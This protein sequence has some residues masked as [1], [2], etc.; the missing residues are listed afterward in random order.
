MAKTRP[1]QTHPFP[2][3]SL[4]PPSL[5]EIVGS[6]LSKHFVRNTREG[7]E[8]KKFSPKK[9][10]ENSPLVHFSRFSFGNRH[11]G[12]RSI[13]LPPLLTTGPGCWTI[14]SPLK[15]NSRSIRPLGRFCSNGSEI[16]ASFK[17]PPSLPLPRGSYRPS[18]FDFRPAR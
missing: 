18:S 16:N 9:A 3:L 14:S 17:C 13:P 8:R 7:G 12:H 6:R 11:R 1:E 10:E 2:S 5:H 4:S 15:L